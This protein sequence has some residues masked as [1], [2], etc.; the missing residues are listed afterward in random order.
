MLFL[1][2]ETAVFEEGTYWNRNKNSHERNSSADKKELSSL[3]DVGM[4]SII[5]HADVKMDE[6]RKWEVQWVETCIVSWDFT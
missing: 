5:V 2:E 3:S 4:L 6:D 1:E